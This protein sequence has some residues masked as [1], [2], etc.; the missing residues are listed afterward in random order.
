MTGR[1]SLTRAFTTLGLVLGIAGCAGPAS[2]SHVAGTGDE[3]RAAHRPKSIVYAVT[4]YV[5]GIGLTA[6][7]STS[8]GWQTANEL[9]TSALVTADFNTRTPVGR[10][11]QHVPT[12]ETG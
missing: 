10:L 12:L 8:G 3:S 11:A 9:H 7:S 6:G 5:N 2:S 1:G 4:D